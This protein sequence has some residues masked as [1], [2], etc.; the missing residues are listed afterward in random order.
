MERI[1]FNH[2]GVE[3]II[4]NI[5]NNKI[6]IQKIKNENKCLAPPFQRWIG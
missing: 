1:M 3:F 2:Y 6:Y 5:T 4:V